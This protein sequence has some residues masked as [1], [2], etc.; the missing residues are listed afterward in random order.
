MTTFLHA[1]FVFIRI[2]WFDDLKVLRECLIICEIYR[3]GRITVKFWFLD[4][5]VGG[6]ACEVR[7]HCF[8]CQ[9]G[10]DIFLSPKEHIARQHCCTDRVRDPRNW[11]APR[12]ENKIFSLIHWI[13]LLIATWCRTEMD[14]ECIAKLSAFSAPRWLPIRRNVCGYLS[15]EG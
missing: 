6:R 14:L 9:R 11:T 13:V 1:A 3:F 12:H 10:S 5:L 15:F 8:V 7:T 2:T 4:L